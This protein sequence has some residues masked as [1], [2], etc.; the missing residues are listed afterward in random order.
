VGE[1]MKKSGT[2]DKDYKPK[3]NLPPETDFPSQHNI[4]E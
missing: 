3:R 4:E 1:A 2:K